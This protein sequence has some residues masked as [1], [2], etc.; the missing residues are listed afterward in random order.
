M[1]KI[2]FR[3]AVLLLSFQLFTACE[4]NYI[5]DD[6]TSS[7][8][9]SDDDDDTSVST[10]SEDTT[11]YNYDISSANTITLNGTS[12]STTSSNVTIDGTTA[13]ITNGG[14]YVVTG[15]LTN[16]QLIIEAGKDTTVKLILNNASIT[17]SSG[18]AIFVKKTKKVVVI[19]PDNTSNSVID[20]S[21]YASDT[22]NAALYSKCDLVFYGNGVLT[23]KGNH[24]DGITSK[25]GLAIKSGTI[26]VTSADDGIRGKDYLVI[27]GGTV[28]VNST[29]DGLKSD[30]TDA[31]TGIISITGGTQK[32]TA[33]SG[34]GIQAEYNV[35]I[36]D[37]DITVTAGGGSSKSKNSSISTK[38][39]KAGSSIS[40]SGD[41]LTIS[42]ADDA[43]HTAGTVAISGGGFNISTSDDAIH[44]ATSIGLSNANISVTKCY[45]GIE[46]KTITVN[47]GN[48]SIIASDDCFNATAGTTSGGAE[49]GDGSYLYIKGGYIY[50]NTTSGDGLDSNGSMEMSGGTAVVS[51]AN[52]TVEVP[53]DYN[54]TFKVTGGFLIA[55]GGNSTMIQAPSTS[56][57]QYCVK[58]TS[59]SSLSSG[60]LF[61]IQ[62]GSGNSILTYKPE[63]AYYTIIFSSSSLAAN[64]TY[65][66]YKGGSCD[67]TIKN[68]LYTSGSYS[69]GTSVTSFKTSSVVT[70][71]GSTASR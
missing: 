33:T 64:T 50:V 53:I 18:P 38:G 68:G 71:L 1:K 55:S 25:D 3:L 30:N 51:G 21:S 65:Y 56:S 69:S 20:G 45:E 60:T 14:Q 28:T 34:D 23:V 27:K 67:G 40:I 29:G 61:H 42:S 16:G 7:S 15:S 36:S 54:G 43:I 41:T 70:S 49:S 58:Y 10:Y 35:I 47:S 52:S 44:G 57:T 26:T 11:D 5:K 19:L 59:S 24:A 6:D 46:G 8:S 39:I 62:D 4:K 22:T 2:L 32:I 63:K 66:I 17:H 12:I 37:A 13:T 31:S 48:Y 9:S